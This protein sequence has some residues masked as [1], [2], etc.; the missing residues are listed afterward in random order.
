MSNC[1]ENIITVT[2]APSIHTLALTLPHTQ[3]KHTHP[4]TRKTHTHTS[5]SIKPVSP[6][7][8]TG[9]VEAV[10]GRWRPLPFD[11]SSFLPK[12]KNSKHFFFFFFYLGLIFSFPFSFFKLFSKTAIK[13]KPI[14]LLPNLDWSKQINKQPWRLHSGTQGKGANLSVAEWLWN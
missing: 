4:L 7:W 9:L 3:A 10:G 5:F 8:L 12:G 13:P 6:Q 14:S 2:H 1:L 11:H